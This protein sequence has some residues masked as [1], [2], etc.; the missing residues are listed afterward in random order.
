[1]VWGSINGASC[2]HHDATPNRND[3]PGKIADKG[4]VA[5]AEVVCREHLIEIQAR[6]GGNLAAGTEKV[7]NNGILVDAL[8]HIELNEANGRR[9]E[10][11]GDSKD[12]GD[13]VCEGL[14]EQLRG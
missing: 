3:V 6:E 9:A 10:L 4:D 7:G 14:A 11:W 5:G 2:V 13:V 8:T 1:L 12:D